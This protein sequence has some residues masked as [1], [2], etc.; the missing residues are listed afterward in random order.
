MKEEFVPDRLSGEPVVFHGCT[1]TEI[2]GIA[3]FG[4]AIFLPLTIL[5]AWKLEQAML[6]IPVGFGLVVMTIW[7]GT[8][9]LQIMKRGKPN[10][11]YQIMIEKKLQKIGIQKKKFI[12]DCQIW[13]LG[14]YK[15]KKR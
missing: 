11:Y 1:D 10:G 3:L 4:V 2:Q 8:Q 6:G 9:K 5:V 14:R 15:T 7:F 12:V 13:T